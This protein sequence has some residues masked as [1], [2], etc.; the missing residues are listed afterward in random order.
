M[1]TR[2]LAVG[3]LALTTLFTTACQ[4]GFSI[5]GAGKKPT[6]DRARRGADDGERVASAGREDEEDRDA[7]DEE[8]RDADDEDAEGGGAAE[9][10]RGDESEPAAASGKSGADWCKGQKTPH[11]QGHVVQWVTNGNDFHHETINA[12]AWVGCSSSRADSQSEAVSTYYSKVKKWSKLPAAELRAYLFALID[13]RDPIQKTCD[14]LD[15]GQQ[16]HRGLGKLLQCKH[17]DEEVGGRDHYYIEDDATSVIASLAAVHSCLAGG[18]SR[19]GG[20]EKV[21]DDTSYALCGAEWRLIKR[22]K[23][24]IDRELDELKVAPAARTKVRIAYR[25]VESTIALT[26]EHLAPKVKDDPVLQ[27]FYYKVP[28]KAYVLALRAN[29]EGA[30]D[31]KAVRAFEA[32]FAKSSRPQI[33]GCYVELRQR[34]MA[35]LGR[36]KVKTYDKARSEMVGP[37]G[38]QISRA[39]EACARKDGQEE[40]ALAVAEFTAKADSFRGP[41]TMVYW[42]LRDALEKMEGDKPT[43]VENLSRLRPA[44]PNPLGR[45]V[46]P[47]SSQSTV[48]GVIKSVKKKSGGVLVQ[49]KT[50]VDKTEDRECWDTKKVHSINDNGTVVYHKK[51]GPWKKVTERSTEDPAFIAAENAA[52]LEPG[53]K[54]LMYCNGAEKP[55]VCAPFAVTDKKGA[56][57]SA[58]LGSKM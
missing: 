32:R 18:N 3:A 39:L 25:Q 8:A 21:D 13:E 17:K 45:P 49:F 31:L 38:Y 5:G 15:L 44:I 7:E 26:D 58:F 54:V 10:D 19:L 11:L 46:T 35:L 29:S 20:V 1:S 42:F 24:A 6:S 55:R 23:S 52:G 30:E 16:A 40:M 9:E 34:L 14:K 57:L 28:D 47:V 22:E 27:A 4:S 53:R 48:E 56:K 36:K 51:C 2:M 12:L 41:R 43:T 33:A 37:I 50:V